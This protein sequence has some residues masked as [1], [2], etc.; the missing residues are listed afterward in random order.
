MATFFSKGTGGAEGKAFLEAIQ[1]VRSY[2][3]FVP[4]I[5]E[6]TGAIDTATDWL[7][8]GI[9]SSAYEYSHVDTDPSSSNDETEGY[10]VGSYGINETSGDEFVCLYAAETAAVWVP[11]P[12][13]LMLDV[14]TVGTVKTYTFAFWD[15]RKRS[16]IDDTIIADPFVQADV[17]TAYDSMIMEVV[18]TYDTSTDLFT[19][20][21]TDADIDT[22]TDGDAINTTNITD[23]TWDE[24]ERDVLATMLFIVY[25]QKALAILTEIETTTV[26]S[27]EDTV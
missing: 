21:Q 20:A 11:I 27:S 13:K 23:T 14:G 5:P 8:P 15:E 17:E 25:S 10:S 26:A 24:G 4:V 18:I 12:R 16:T 7:Y 22:T 6:M 3:P 2:N 19:V 1:E 9:H